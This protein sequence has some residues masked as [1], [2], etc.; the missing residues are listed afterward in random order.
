MNPGSNG[1]FSDSLPSVSDG[2]TKVLPVISRRLPLE[3]P[4]LIAGF[5]DSGMIGSVTINHI[6][7]Q[8]RMHQIAYVESEYIMPAAVFIGKRFR[9]AFR[10]YG[11]DSGTICALICEVPVSAKGTYSIVNTILDWSISCGVNKIVVLGGILPTNFSPPYLLERR[12]MLLRNELADEPYESTPAFSD[13]MAVPDDAIIVGLAGSLLS[14]SAARRQSCMALMIPTVAEAPDP[15]GAAI[16]L[17]ALPKILPGVTIDT[18][19]LRQKVEEIKK[20][21]Q[22]FLRMHQ[23]QMQEYER[24]ASRETERM[25]K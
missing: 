11:N 18:S 4:V 8:L 12:P 14:V 21:L 20:H 1:R 24:A 25:Y 10:I 2:Y 16:V 3:N 7:E 6:I 23:Q 5:S 17:E 13:G 22:E 19:S 15:E 9:H